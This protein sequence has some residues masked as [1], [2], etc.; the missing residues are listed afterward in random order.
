MN[1]IILFPF[2][3]C[4][5]FLNTT[6]KA[7]MS[8]NG[9]DLFGN[10]WIH[11]NESYYKFSINTD[12]IYKISYADLAA[13]NFPFASI[14]A[15][16]IKVFHL[17]EQVPL[18]ATTE[19]LLT[20][21]DYFLFYGEKNR[22]EFDK[23]LFKNTADQLNPEYS[24]YTDE[25]SY[26][27]TW[28]N[29]VS[30][31]I[32]LINNDLNSPVPKDEYCYV[33]NKY[34][35]NDLSNKK[36]YGGDHQR[37][38]DYDAGQGYGSN[39]FGNLKENGNSLY[40]AF[41]LDI[42]LKQLYA[43]NLP[44]TITST[45]AGGRGEI[46]TAH[47]AVFKIDGQNFDEDVFNGF[48]TRKLEKVLIA[49]QINPSFKYSVDALAHLE[50]NLIFSNLQITY[51][52]KFDFEQSSFTTI[53]LLASPIRRYLEIENFNGSNQLYL[54]DS[55]LKNYIRVDR[56]ANGKYKVALPAMNTDRVIYIWNPSE[57]KTIPASKNV[58]F[59]T[60]KSNEINYLIVSNKK[61]YDDGNGHNYV[62]EYANYRSSVEGGSFKVENVEVE[63]IYDQFGYGIKEHTL[64]L[65]NFFQYCK[66]NYP[67]LKYVLLIGKGLEYKNYRQKPEAELESMFVPTYSQPGADYMLVSDKFRTPLFALGRIPCISPSEIKL[68]LD[69][70]KGHEQV[71][72]NTSH[73]IANR[74]WTKRVIHLSGGDPF[75]YKEIASQLEIMADSITNNKFGGNVTTFYKD[76]SGPTQ[77]VSL[78]DITKLVN[79][80]AS[81]IS[82]MGHSAQFKLDF[83]IENVRAYKNKDRY[84][85]FLAM[86]CFAGAMFDEVRSI[87]E[88]YN[89]A[90]E[91]GSIIYLSNSTAGLSS[92]LGIYGAE[93]YRNF[94][95]NWYT[96]S[97]GEAVLETNKKFMVNSEEDILTQAMS[98]TYNGDPALRFLNNQNTDFTPDG[99]SAKVDSKVI[100]A[101]QKNFKFDVDL[102]NLGAN[103][104]DSLHVKLIQ[105]LPTGEKF[106]LFNSKIAAPI[107]RKTFSFSVPTQGYKASGFNKLYLTLDP[108][109]EIAEGPNPD[110]ELNNE[111]EIS[112]GIKGFEYFVVANEAVP[113]YPAEFSIINTDKPTLIANNPNTLA[114]ASDYTFEMDTTAYFNSPLFKTYT[115]NQIGGI[116]SWETNANL[117]P[118][119]VYYWRVAPK[120]LPNA[121]EAWQQ[122]SFIYIPGSSEGWNQSHF[123][124]FNRDALENTLLEEPNRVIKFKIGS[125][126]FRATNGHIE[127]PQYYRPKIFVRNEAVMNFEYWTQLRTFSGFVVSVF[128]HNTGNLWINKTG[129]DFNSIGNTSGNQST[130]GK[131]FFIFRTELK[132][133]RQNFISFLKNDVPEDDIVLLFGLDQENYNAFEQYWE[134]DGPENLYSVMSGYGLT[135]FG[136]LK[137]FGFLPFISAFQ[138]SHKDFSP[139]ESLGNKFAENEV[140]T[141]FN[142]SERE[143]NIKSTIVGPA[144]NWDKFLWN[145][146]RYNANEDKQEIRIYG[147]DKNNKD[148]LLF[149]PFT[150]AVKDLSK[151]DAKVFPN[152]RLEWHLNDEISRTAS[153]IDYWRVLY[154][155]LPDAAFNPAKWF[156]KNKDTLNQ[157]DQFTT[158]IMA[159]NISNY[160]MDSLLVRFTLVDSKNFVTS[161]QKRMAP[162]TAGS[163]LIIP[164]KTSTGKQS[165]NYR[166]YIELNPGADQPE[167]NFSNNVSVIEYYVRQDKR[168][169]YIDVVFSGDHI[170]DGGLVSPKTKIQIALIDENREQPLN[171]TSLFDI[172]LL[173]PNNDIIPF[174]FGLDNVEFVP[175]DMASPNAKNIALVIIDGDFKLDGEYELWIKAHDNDGNSATQVQYVTAFRVKTEKNNKL[176]N[177]PNPFSDI[178]HFVYT[179]DGNEI[180]ANYEIQIMNMDGKMVNSLGKDKIGPLAL[181][182][183]MISYD[184]DGTDK[185]GQKLKSGVYYYR[186][187]TDKS[188]V[189]GKKYKDQYFDSNFGRMVI[190]R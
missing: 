26:F 123:F 143:G 166:L 148:S 97:I 64:S 96:K 164:F 98:I 178:T 108:K 150:D 16:Q 23:P 116:I 71:L 160:G 155:G 134:D 60:F 146:D 81:I 180:P 132:E 37:F 10:E 83:N 86:G 56:D 40:K 190:I 124:Q 87:S 48:D 41:E 157:G 39:Y 94:G 6:I 76:N 29:S 68:Y 127:L 156:K 109:N 112:N 162:L 1:R 5:L 54:Y 30:S 140:I 61:L 145:Y 183:H 105:E 172:Q 49:N 125:E 126:E 3:I 42:Q 36:I 139:V 181:G 22:G 104:W 70:V 66:L 13:M 85:L 110:A 147:I 103:I 89:F 129:T 46:A 75:I 142:V 25:A 11:P 31:R 173:D 188:K 52:H 144:R 20:N 187:I 111:L 120:G 21:Q 114:S 80:G 153:N 45:I 47:K 169:P 63:E 33:T 115:T 9:K 151:I 78:T 12:G 179:L 137:Q 73:S 59:R 177:I 62:Q 82:F 161:S 118:N 77:N 100:Y 99:T 170:V 72:K 149:D 91:R 168:K 186:F 95:R 43:D 128:D 27:V 154:K 7:Q 18:M 130:V 57:I 131:T 8:F 163:N 185:G 35:Y 158:E 141:K 15:S 84:H 38:P 189:K 28:D 50:D 167:S 102:V 174:N 58:K 138:K 182:S 176:I 184:Y 2:L 53:T 93:L 92:I 101:S 133:Y 135:E 107:N 136:K 79:D 165:G 117:I 119:K 65:V 19:G 88:E 34:V 113:T 32:K 175:A 51:P 69:K 122:S 14:V 171:D 44:V 74:E 106:E 4:F 121:I 90:P 55:G 152:L 159:Q 24:M 17:G 67:N